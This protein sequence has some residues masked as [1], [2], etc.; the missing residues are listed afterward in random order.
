MRLTV[1]GFIQVGG[2]HWASPHNINIFD[3]VIASTAMINILQ[4]LKPTNKCWHSPPLFAFIN[5]AAGPH[6][7]C[8]CGKWSESWLSCNDSGSDRPIH[9][10]IFVANFLLVQ[11]M[12][13]IVSNISCMSSISWWV[14]FQCHSGLVRVYSC[15]QVLNWARCETCSN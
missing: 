8:G 10:K 2:M 11:A 4:C 12:N 14:P 1:Q 13:L 6:F 15:C 5:T 7:K 9:K 3:V